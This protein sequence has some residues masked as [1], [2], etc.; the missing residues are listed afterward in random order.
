M[1]IQT[2]QDTGENY[3]VQSSFDGACYQINKPDCVVANVGDNFTLNHQVDSL[4]V[5]FNA[6]SECIICGNFFKIMS[7][8]SIELA[9]NAVI[10]LCATINKSYSTGFTGFFSQRT[11]SNIQNGNINGADSERDLLLY[12]IT[13]TGTGVSSVVDK[14][15]IIGN[16]Y[17]LTQSE[18]DELTSKE[19]YARYE[20]YE[21]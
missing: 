10:Y 16:T 21:D 19:N 20:I 5:T 15:K 7:L 18:F 14:R 13:T 2:L 4:N 9:P 3:K 11:S 17:A 12:I 8:E 1:A 6:G